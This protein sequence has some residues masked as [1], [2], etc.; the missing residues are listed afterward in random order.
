MTEPKEEE[1]KRRYFG[2]TQRCADNCADPKHYHARNLSMMFGFAEKPAA[3]HETGYDP[4]Y[5]PLGCCV[6]KPLC[7]QCKAWYAEQ[8]RI[9][10]L[11]RAV[12][13]EAI[14]EH[15]R[16]SDREVTTGLDRAVDALLKARPDLNSKRF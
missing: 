15:K 14:S 16:F 9:A 3:E 13:E 4:D 7:D 11:E 10:E 12:I 2:P 6:D 1:A 5:S 8:T